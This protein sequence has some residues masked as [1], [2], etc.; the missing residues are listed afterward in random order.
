MKFLV[1]G[2]Y[3]TD[4]YTRVC[5]TRLNPDDP[6]K[7]CYKIIG[8]DVYCQGGAGN[9]YGQ[10]VALDSS[11]V[12]SCYG[13]GKISRT[14]LLGPDDQVVMRLDRDS[15][16][17]PIDHNKLGWDVMRRHAFKAIFVSDY[18]KGSITNELMEK[19]ILP[20]RHE[21]PIFINAKKPQDIA[22][23]FDSR[24][25]FIS[26]NESEYLRMRAQVPCSLIMT[27]LVVTNSESVK[28]IVGNDRITEQPCFTCD[29]MNATGAGDTFFAVFGATIA[30]LVPNFGLLDNLA[31]TNFAMR[32][33][34][35]FAAA[36]VEHPLT[37][38]VNVKLA[39]KF[40][41]TDALLL[42]KVAEYKVF[43]RITAP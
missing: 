24:V 7:P 36:A 29:P 1:I 34:N 19:T 40:I 13:Y 3:M 16:V 11:D 33:A 30:A 2:D 32:L 27:P 26:M 4:I 15:E 37:I 14:R 22:A 20:Y 39:Q 9:V 42:H 31:V 8:S 41:S 28:L 38:A 5:V 6:M 17:Q 10:L 25:S 18:G 43:E 35:A 23:Y 12:E 21:S